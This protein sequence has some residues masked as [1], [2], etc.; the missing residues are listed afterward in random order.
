MTYEAPSLD[1]RERDLDGGPR[2]E[3]WL[4]KGE[5]TRAEQ[6]LSSWIRDCLCLAV[7][8]SGSAPEV[9]AYLERRNIGALFAELADL[10]P[11]VR[12]RSFTGDGPG[13]AY[14]A[15]FV[16]RPDLVPRWLDHT[17]EVVG[18]N[19][20]SRFWAD[21]HRA[22]DCLYRGA[23]YRRNLP[24]KPSGPQVLAERQMAVIEAITSGDDP[25]GEFAAADAEFRRANQ[26][27]RLLLNAVTTIN[28]SAVDPVRFDLAR[29]VL[30]RL[31][32]D[33][34]AR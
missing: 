15:W 34:R 6:S 20:I 5:T 23:P 4:N 9:R 24:S 27:R 12:R 29:W 2:H 21:Y 31:S 26:D 16:E 13:F 7:R 19:A 22:I 30:A 3:S 28:P 33:N 17:S 18:S 14:L 32:S 11:N 10:W 8:R 1:I 25:S